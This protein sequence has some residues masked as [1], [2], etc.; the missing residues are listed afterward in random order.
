MIVSSPY[1]SFTLIK[2][3]AVNLSPCWVK[4]N[5]CTNLHQIPRVL[6]STAVLISSYITP[7]HTTPNLHARIALHL[8]ILLLYL[9]KKKMIHSSS[10]AKLN[11]QQYAKS[12]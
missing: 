5:H 12:K 8:Y 11:F 4:C 1:V 3:R 2:R 7:D 10:D 9:T 6:A